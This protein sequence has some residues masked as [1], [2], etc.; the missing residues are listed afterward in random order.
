MGVPG[1]FSWLL[2]HYKNKNF[3][4]DKIE[5]DIKTLYID[6]NCLFHP[7]CFHI[8]NAYPELDN[9][10]KLE[11]RMFKRITNYIDYIVNFCNP[12]EYVFISVDGVAPV[13][14]INQQRKRRYRS[15]QD[16]K[17]K[18]AIKDKYN[19]LYNKNWNNTVI[20][21][22]TEFME[23]L[24]K[25]L[26]QYCKKKTMNKENAVKYIYSSYM[27]PGEGEHKILQ[28]IRY[29]DTNED[30]VVIYGL[31][32]DLFFLGM[33]SQKNNIYLLRE[34]F[35]LENRDSNI[36]PE[37]A[38]PVE[39]INEEL[40]YVDVDKTKECYNN[41]I[42]KIIIY[43]AKAKRIF[44]KVDY[45]FCNDF[46]FL[47]YLLG[48]DF[49]PHFPSL[50]IKKNGLD[51]ILDKYS[52]VYI[53]IGQQLVGLKDNKVY[54][55]NIFLEYLLKELS[56][57]EP[58]YFTEVLPEYK[59]KLETKKCPTTDPYSKEV[60]ELDNM[61]NL[62]IEDPIKLGI[63]SPTEYKSRYYEHYYSQY[64]DKSNNNSKELLIDDMCNRYLEGLLWVTRY[65]F[66]GCPDW[67]WQYIYNHG[68]FISD[69]YNF[70][71][72]S[73]SSINKIKFKINEPLTPSVQL[74]CVL[75]PQCLDLI[76]SGYKDYMIKDKVKGHKN[77]I[78]YMFPDNFELDTLYKDVYYQCIPEIPYINI[79]LV[80]NT[81]KDEPLTKEEEHRNKVYKSFIFGK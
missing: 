17:I 76:S 38:D 63:D 79:N 35:H 71:R 73:K 27:T 59:K 33:A 2:R 23:K 57:Y 11:K 44:A 28:N 19:I 69:V 66:C 81:I 5:G 4:V 1:F 25:T 15:I 16:N 22:G 45:D 12:K 3:I 55:N 26:I 36:I 40:K 30:K 62:T 75:P 51:V 32:A 39:Y 8:L 65:Y 18:D 61:T 67:H 14:K 74:L 56:D 47:C 64:I 42:K 43:K 48:N 21:P 53:N 54:I 29:H 52:D 37:D 46:I 78:K 60:W 34:S 49:L 72:K 7:Q 41:Q 80:L 6:A 24:H 9:K 13:A 20:T 70:M 50:D 10:E 68:P 58:I 77:K 31:D